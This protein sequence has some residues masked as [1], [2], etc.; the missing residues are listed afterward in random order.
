M[1]TLPDLVLRDDDVVP[2]VRLTYGFWPK[3]T[4]DLGQHQLGSLYSVT[5]AL[6]Q[7]TLS[8]NAKQHQ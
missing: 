4:W 2:V 7:N 5:G 3:R 6:L 8:L 1:R